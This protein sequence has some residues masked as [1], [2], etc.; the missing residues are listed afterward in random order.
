MFDEKEVI[1]IWI[2]LEFYKGLVSKFDIKNLEKCFYYLRKIYTKLKN[3]GKLVNCD[4]IFVGKLRTAKDELIE[5]SRYKIR[6][7]AECLAE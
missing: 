1:Q 7:M 4:E 6:L 5:S 3:L 2:E